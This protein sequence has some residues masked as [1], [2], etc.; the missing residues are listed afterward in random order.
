[1]IHHVLHLFGP[2]FQNLASSLLIGG[3]CYLVRNAVGITTSCRCCCFWQSGAGTFVSVGTNLLFV[4]PTCSVIVVVVIVVVVAVVIVIIVVVVVIV[5]AIS[6]T[7]IFF[8]AFRCHSFFS[9]ALAVYMKG[10]LANVQ[11][12]WKVV[13]VH[14]SYQLCVVI[15]IG[16]AFRIQMGRCEKMMMIVVVRIGAIVVVVKIVFVSRDH[17]FQP[18]APAIVVLLL[19]GIVAVMVIVVIFLDAAI[20]LG[21]NG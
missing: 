4:E 17:L 10:V 15:M 1:M 6:I 20:V 19:V 21:G 13:K 2:I 8:F 7:A 18:T 5:I 14:L 12:E 9:F 3:R 16:S 11:L